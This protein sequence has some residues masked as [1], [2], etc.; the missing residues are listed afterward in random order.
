MK[1]PGD[2]SYRVECVGYATLKFNGEMADTLFGTLSKITSKQNKKF[3]IEDGDGTVLNVSPYQSTADFL[4][5][6]PVNAELNLDALHSV[7][8]HGELTFTEL[9]VHHFSLENNICF[10]HTDLVGNIFN[11]T[12]DGK[13]ISEKPDS[14][15]I[16]HLDHFYREN[17]TTYHD[18]E[19]RFKPPMRLFVIHSDKTGTEIMD[20]EKCRALLETTDPNVVRVKEDVESD[21]L[22]NA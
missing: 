3:V 14:H 18:V 6:P 7:R 13:I 11:V 19:E 22:A 12:Y 15:I 4:V 16:Q 17:K 8:E 10:Q 9:G 20:K 21:D 2:T 1:F 5:P